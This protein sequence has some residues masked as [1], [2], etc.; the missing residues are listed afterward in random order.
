MNIINILREFPGE[1]NFGGV[2]FN[3]G[4]SPKST[5]NSFNHF[6]RKIS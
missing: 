3:R 4:L 2:A 5:Y 1:E 6:V